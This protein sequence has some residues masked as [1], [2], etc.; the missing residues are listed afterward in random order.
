MFFFYIFARVIKINRIP[1]QLGF[2][3]FFRN[4]K[5]ISGGMAEAVNEKLEENCD[6]PSE[7][8]NTENETEEAVRLV[9]SNL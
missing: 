5:H 9:F 7:K 6:V 2:H 3:F 8:I 1:F 4:V